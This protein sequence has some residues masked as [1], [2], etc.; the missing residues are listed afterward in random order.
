MAGIFE[1]HQKKIKK[2]SLISFL[3]IQIYQWN[4]HR[5]L[6]AFQLT[7]VLKLPDKFTAMPCTQ[8]KTSYLN[9]LYTVKKITNTFELPTGINQ[10]TRFQS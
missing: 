5:L 9:L 4:C 8:S 3:E 10:F 6:K 1:I 2:K 7:Y